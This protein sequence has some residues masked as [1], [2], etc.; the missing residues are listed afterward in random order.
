VYNQSAPIGASDNITW[1]SDHV[2]WTGA[3]G[4]Q[5]LVENQGT[6]AGYVAWS[7][8]DQLIRLEV[9]VKAMRVI[10]D[11]GTIALHIE[12]LSGSNDSFTFSYLFRALFKE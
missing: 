4:S 11:T 1:S 2:L 6:P 12:N 7:M 8:L 10:A 5:M 3:A 9:D